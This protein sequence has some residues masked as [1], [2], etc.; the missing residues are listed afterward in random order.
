MPM[1]P[2]RKV[3]QGLDT[4]IDGEATAGERVRFALHLAMCDPC[5][6]Y[7]KQYAAVRDAAGQ[8]DAAD[9][10]EDFNEVMGRIVNKV[11]GE[12]ADG[13]ST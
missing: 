9:L 8:I 4:I 12:R 10:P 13:G 1:R 7:Y 3:M 11:F 6:R 2:C 5:E